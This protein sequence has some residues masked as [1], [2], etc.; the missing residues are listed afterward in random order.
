MC[1]RGD[2]AAAR[3]AADDGAI[4]PDKSALLPGGTGRFANVT[5]YTRGING[6]MV[7]VADFPLGR[8]AAN[9]W[10]LETRMPTVRHG[11]FPL[12]H[13]NRVLVAAGGVVA[14]ASS[15]AILQSLY[16]PLV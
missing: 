7:D 4:A 3:H 12:L 5:S 10:R 11:I 8:P 1:G 13:N 15:S 9:T 14:G 16:L 6:V 2:A